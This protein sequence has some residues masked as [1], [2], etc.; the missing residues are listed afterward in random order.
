MRNAIGPRS[1]KSPIL[2]ATSLTGVGQ[3]LPESFSRQI[4]TLETDDGLVDKDL[5]GSTDVLRDLF[6]VAADSHAAG[7]RPMLALMRALGGALSD[8]TA[9]H[10]CDALYPRMGKVSLL[11]FQPQP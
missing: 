5:S 2:A 1:Q 11:R 9:L 8:A 6:S 3:L 10:T 7:G 4:R